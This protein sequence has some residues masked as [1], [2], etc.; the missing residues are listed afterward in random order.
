[1]AAPETKRVG[2]EAY[3]VIDTPSFEATLV[4]YDPV[5]ANQTILAGWSEVTLE[6]GPEAEE[7]VLVELP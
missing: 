2:D 7:P 3:F 4:P 5:I 1:V 6:R